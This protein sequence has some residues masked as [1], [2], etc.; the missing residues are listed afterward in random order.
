MQE[1]YHLYHND[2]ETSSSRA[3]V[4]MQGT[5]SFG[6]YFIP[7][8]T[9]FHP[10]EAGQP[11]DRGVVT[12]RSFYFPITRLVMTPDRQ[13]QHYVASPLPLHMEGKEVSLTLDLVRR[14]Q[15]MRR[16][17]A[18]HLIK[19]LLER[20]FP[21]LKVEHERYFSDQ[22]TLSFSSATSNSHGASPDLQ[23]LTAFLQREVAAITAKP[24]PI[25]TAYRAKTRIVQIEGLQPHI[26]QG[27]HLTTTAPLR[28]TLIRKVHRKSRSEITIDYSTR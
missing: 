25:L 22:T 2:S 11:E 9:I 15:L 21:H 4:V 18:G 28:S 16:H 10:E 7:D 20:Y 24:R 19:S 23:E 27:I 12:F 13:I 5:T 17:T 8:Q 14:R 26:C 3:L 6:S 1:D